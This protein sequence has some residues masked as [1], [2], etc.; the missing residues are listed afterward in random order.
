[1]QVVRRG[2]YLGPASPRVRKQ[3]VMHVY[4]ALFRALAEKLLIVC[5]P[6]L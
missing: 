1:M 4:I 6:K 2:A 3:R 5:A